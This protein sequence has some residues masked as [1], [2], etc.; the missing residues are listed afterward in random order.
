[1]VQRRISNPGQ[2]AHHG[3]DV[4]V[5]ES[6]TKARN[7]NKYL[8]AGYRVLSSYGHVR[9]LPEKDGSVRP[10]E[11]FR[12]IYELLADKEKRVAEIARALKDADHLYLATDPDREG[13]AIS[14]HLLAAL[15]DRGAINGVDI[16]RVV[17]HEITKRAVL[18]AMHHP[19]DLQGGLI[20]AYQAR[21]A[22]DYLVG[23]TLS[24]VL[25]R[26]LHGARS[27]GRVQSVAL[28][29]ICERENEIEAFRPQEYWSIQAAFTTP[30]DATFD[31]RLSG[32]DGKK[33]EKFDIPSE[34]DARRAVAAI[35]ARQFR[36][37][38]LEK[39]QVQRHPAPPFATGTLQ[40]EA[41]RKLGFS[42]ERTMRTAQRLFE[43]VNLAGE[44]VG[45]ITYM[46]T[47]SVQ[48][49]AEA[50]EAARRQIAKAYGDRYLPEKPR[51]YK[52]RTKNAQEAHEAIR[53]TDMGR[54]P[55]AVGR[56]LDD[57][58]RRLYELIWK[59]TLA[60]Q[61]AS[62]V[63][64][65]V[66]AEIG[67]ADR[68]V[69]LRATGSTVAFDGFLRLYQE[70]R[71]DP[72][73]DD[74]EG[75]LLPP[76]APGDP[77]RRGEITPR[78]HFTEPPP[79]YTEASLVRRL[80]ELGIGRP[81]TYATIISVLQDRNYV[82]L[83]S[84]RFVPEE[85]GR[86]VT[87]FLVAFFDQYVQPEFTADLETQ[88]DEIAAGLRHWKHVLRDF[89]DPFSEQVD[90][91]KERR[92]AEVI[93]ALNELL[94]PHLFPPRADGTDPRACPQ[95]GSGRLSLKIG[96]YGAFVGCSNYPECRYTRRLVEPAAADPEQIEVKERILGVD[97]GTGE[98]IRLRRG[99]YGP[100]VQRGE[101]E[102]AKR[103]SLPPN[104]SP[105]QLDLETAQKLLAL[106][107]ELGRHPE[108]GQP[109]E[110]GINRYGPYIKH[111]RF[112]RLG[113]EDDVLTTGMNRALALL[114]D[115]AKRTRPGP[116]VLKE[117]GPH[118]KDKKPVVLY[119]GRFGPY[120][121][122]GRQNASLPKGHDPGALTLEEA[123][124]LLQQK[125]AKGKAASGAR[126][127]A[128]AK[129]R[130]NGPRK[131]AAK[132]TG[133]RGSRASQS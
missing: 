125:A 63:L 13:E 86:L 80:E 20:D 105:D 108:T 122:H 48:V 87:A 11:D 8:G 123:V 23:F 90:E 31:A 98:E 4:V 127:A 66:V 111:D 89:W 62:A 44:M 124:N 39:K 3:M 7:I 49:S 59:R 29:L 93:E 116:K 96:R 18:E 35:E 51:A 32:L 77:L 26:K 102:G 88:L 30:S 67:S 50:M 12:I 103:S 118:P 17:F 65:R 79:R 130:A 119:Q 42:A 99:P 128:G 1:V 22:L 41:A 95:C 25:W 107:R 69:G 94:A 60:S 120:V 91:V 115:A 16:R 72:A 92:I 85:R 5:V 47:D 70:G 133:Q 129:A 97:P 53:P 110:V 15:K 112:V 38:S 54:A 2:E 82:R 14:W 36:V 76:M 81:S 33:L 109:I 45:L 83:E 73:Q 74:E 55:Q 9:D 56:F 57:D 84:R 24:P 61:M 46:R 52:T 37:E 131:T 64:D 106:P 43:G 132:A 34:T 10:E 6:P 100:Y 71:D 19:R 104:L 75:G 78:Q 27:A 114:E 58:Q 121:K 117:L 28:R 101:G 113:P 126:T 40:Q 21:R 68:Q